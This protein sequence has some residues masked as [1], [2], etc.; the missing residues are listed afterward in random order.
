[1][2][3]L[4]TLIIQLFFI[5]FYML[6]KIANWPGALAISV[7]GWF[8]TTVIYFVLSIKMLLKWEMKKS[9]SYFLFTLLVLSIPNKIFFEYHNIIIHFL[10]LSSFLFVFYKQKIPYSPYYKTLVY[11]V[12]FINVLLFLLG[13]NYI[14]KNAGAFYAYK[15]YSNDGISKCDFKK[16]DSLNNNFDAEISTIIHY[17]INKVY[18][19]TPAVIASVMQ[20]D[21][22]FYVELSDKLVAHEYYH[23]KI[24]ETISRQLYK[25][26]SK[27]PFSNKS[28]TQDII[29]KYLDSLRIKQLNYDTETN[30][31]LNQDVQMQW[32][33]N[34]DKEIDNLSQ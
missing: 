25:T 26:L 10:I 4:V 11:I 5:A 34:I 3:H 16:V 18:N 28:T 13:D 23:F 7:F 9:I 8:L 2:L 15:P 19:Y 17:K 21:E 24:T 32:Q 20:L 29:Y 1:M 33:I 30:H 6:C 12:L 14:Y 22:C 31:S 27:S